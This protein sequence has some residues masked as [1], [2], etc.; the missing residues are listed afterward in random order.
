MHHHIIAVVLMVLVVSCKPPRADQ[1][2]DGGAAVDSEAGLATVDRLSR[3]DVGYGV[4][5]A[6]G[7]D[8]LVAVGAPRG[9][10]EMGPPGAVELFRR[11]RAPLVIS[12]PRIKGSDP[13]PEKFG[14]TVDFRGKSLIIGSLAGSSV[15]QELEGAWKQVAFAPSATRFDGPK[16]STIGTMTVLANGVI[17]S[18]PDPSE[19][20][21]LPG[22]VVLHRDKARGVIVTHVVRGGAFEALRE[23]PLTPE[24][25]HLVNGNADHVPA[26]EHPGRGIIIVDGNEFRMGEKVLGTR[27]AKKRSCK[28]MIGLDGQCIPRSEFECKDV[29][30]TEPNVQVLKLRDRYVYQWDSKKGWTERARGIN[31]IYGENTRVPGFESEYCDSLIPPLPA[32]P[33]PEWVPDTPAVV[34]DPVLVP[35]HF[36]GLYSSS[37]GL[38]MFL[39]R[40]GQERTSDK[41]LFQVVNRSPALLSRVDPL[42]PA[43]VVQEVS[44]QRS[45][46]AALR[47]GSE[48]D[49]NSWIQALGISGPDFFAFVM[50]ADKARPARVVFLKAPPRTPDSTWRNSRCPEDVNGDGQVTPTDVRVVINAINRLPRGILPGE[51]PSTE[52]QV[53]VNGDRYATS[54]D[55]LRVTNRINRGDTL[56]PEGEPF[57][58]AALNDLEITEVAST[59]GM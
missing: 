31:C 23:Q 51:R 1:R 20:Q 25:S 39:K 30:V 5:V 28:C 55:S 57:S 15:Y 37:R 43:T 50:P 47:I 59:L 16:G 41:V 35:S 44:L 18:W 34:T 56:C 45:K 12:A 2:A 40:S 21:V 27:T 46:I 7:G 10:W 52:K 17:H 42:A 14:R 26:K 48:S 58:P 53:D 11:D 13:V 9:H 4:S 32:A 54:Q 49:P 3:T 6:V 24:L 33:P 36:N 38:F 19:I 29:T 22:P 8:G